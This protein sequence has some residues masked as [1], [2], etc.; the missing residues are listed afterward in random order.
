MNLWN[1]DGNISLLYMRLYVRGFH[2]WTFIR[3]RSGGRLKRNFHQN[4]YY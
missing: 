3:R 4:I 2:T 1:G